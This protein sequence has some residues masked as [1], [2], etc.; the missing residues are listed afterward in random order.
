MSVKIVG[1]VGVVRVLVIGDF[2]VPWRRPR[3]PGVVLRAVRGLRPDLV[4]CTGDFTDE[5]VF[6]VVEGLGP[7]VAVRGEADCFYLPRCEFVEVGGL[8]F[9]VVH[10]EGVVHSPVFL[11]RRF[12]AG[13]ADVVVLG[14]VHEPYFYSVR[15]GEKNICFVNP[16]SATGV[17]S[18]VC[19]ESAPSFVVVDVEKGG[20]WARVFRFIGGGF[21]VEVYGYL[22]VIS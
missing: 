18:G 14:H 12:W 11:C 20:L 10:G 2:H 16:G 7:L 3:V 22:K 1:G 6:C 13:V 4:L 21:R 15:V 17:S 8:M 9:Q 5:E 19:G